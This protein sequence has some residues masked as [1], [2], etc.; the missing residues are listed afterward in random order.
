[1]LNK[2]EI[3]TIYLINLYIYMSTIDMIQAIKLLKELSIKYPTLDWTLLSCLGRFDDITFVCTTAI[4]DFLRWSEPII[5]YNGF[6]LSH[7]HTLPKTF[8]S[9]EN[10]IGFIDEFLDCFSIGDSKSQIHR[11]II[12][13][14]FEKVLYATYVRG[15]NDKEL[16]SQINILS[17]LNIDWADSIL[18]EEYYKLIDI[19]NHDN[20]CKDTRFENSV[21]MLQVLA[22]KAYE[23]RNN[24]IL[25]ELYN[26]MNNNP[27][28]NVCKIVSVF[29]H[30]FSIS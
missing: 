1:L 11:K 21:N 10:N 17:N 25:H 24:I 20:I 28:I 18:D 29:L 27:D 26:V 13:R 30:S 16:S 5:I 4:M 7:Y 19:L 23:Q 2:I 3:S 14:I 9:K 6:E 22:T 12:I 8:Y 15:V